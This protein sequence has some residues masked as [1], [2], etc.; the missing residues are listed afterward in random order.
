LRI[1]QLCID[2]RIEIDLDRS[3]S[4][5]FA[6]THA[7]SVENETTSLS[8]VRLPSQPTAQT[9]QALQPHGKARVMLG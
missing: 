7:A 3:H 2:E 4:H 6:S 8:E 9:L 5:G 1:D